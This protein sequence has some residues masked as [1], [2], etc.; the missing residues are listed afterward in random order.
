MIKIGDWRS[1][2]HAQL[3]NLGY[4]LAVDLAVENETTTNLRIFAQDR[5]SMVA[6]MRGLDLLNESVHL[7]GHSCTYP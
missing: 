6:L 3:S 2:P 5:F 4:D 1:G 7:H